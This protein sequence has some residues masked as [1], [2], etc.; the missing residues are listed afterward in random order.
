MGL[1]FVVRDSSGGILFSR[2]GKV[3]L[4]SPKT[5]TYCELAAFHVA[6]SWAVQSKQ[7]KFGIQ[8]DYALA[9]KIILDRSPPTDQGNMVLVQ[10]IKK[11]LHALPADSYKV[12]PHYR[13]C[14][15]VA[16]IL[17]KEGRMMIKLGFVDNVL[18][19]NF[20]K[21]IKDNTDGVWFKLKRKI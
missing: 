20:D 19:N 9:V 1:G 12:L 13:E 21:A 11:L 16:D 4:S 6:L 3:V 8:S 2:Y 18:P 7:V 10:E 14:N 17:A 15:E 5:S